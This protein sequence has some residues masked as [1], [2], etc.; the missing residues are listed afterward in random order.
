M[1]QYFYNLKYIFKNQYPYSKIRLILTYT[2]LMMKSWF[3]FRIARKMFRGEV[4]HLRTRIMGFKVNFFSYPQLIHLFEDIFIYQVYALEA[5]GDHPLIID[6]GANVGLASI[7]F[8]KARKDAR[9]MAFEP[10][11][12]AFNLL[13]K[14]LAEN[15]KKLGKIFLYNYA[16]WGN[17]E[18][19]TLHWQ[20]DDEGLVRMSLFSNNSADKAIK[21]KGV[22]LSEFINERIDFLK[23]DVEGA[24]ET[25]LDELIESK[26]LDQVGQIAMEFHPGYDRDLDRLEDKMQRL[27]YDVYEQSLDGVPETIVWFQGK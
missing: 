20:R 13:K 1:R 27:G 23:I 6:A 8:K 25:I 24:E 9:V 12:K 21:V 14:T 3:F 19:L 22:K 7:Y 16:L 2:K 4:A 10:D 18:D 11:P 5:A 26:K 15:E 17:E